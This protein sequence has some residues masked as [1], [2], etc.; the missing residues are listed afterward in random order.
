MLPTPTKLP[1]STISA[2]TNK[3]EG[4]PVRYALY[5]RWS[6]GKQDAENTKEGQYN[7]LRAHAESKGGVVVK[8]YIDEGV[9]GKRD[10]R[11]ALNE[12]MRDA[13]NRIRPFDEVLVW[14]FDRFGRRAS[15]MDRRI[16]ELEE[17]GIGIVAIQQPIQGK[18]SVVRLFRT[19][20]GGL[21][22]YVSDNMGEDISRG[23]MT[24]ATH[25][26][27][28]N[29]SVP[30][31]YKREYR[32]DRNR[33]RPFLVPDP[34][35]SWIVVRAFGLYRDGSSTS[36]IAEVYR[37]ENVPGPTEKPWT[38]K[39]VGSMLKNIEYAGFIHFGKRSKFDD[40]E[41]IIPWPE[42]ELISLEEYNQV[43]EIMASRN[44]ENRHPREVASVHLLSGLVFCHKG[45]FKMSPT[46]GERSY[47]NCNGKRNGIC[48]ACDTPN[49][50][51]ERLDT[52]VLQHVLDRIIIKENTERILVIVA[53]SQTE[54]TMEVEE[55]LKNVN[56]EIESQKASRRKL[57]SFVEGE[58][59]VVPADIAERMVEIR[60]ELTRLEAKALEARA[61][62]SN[63]KAL[64]SNPE[65]VLAYATKLETYLRGSNVDLTK[66]I[67][68][69][70]IVEVRVAP[71]EQENT[72]NVTIKYRVPT[73][74][75]G[76]AENTDIEVMA[77]RK[78]A[79]S[80]GTPVKAGMTRADWRKTNKH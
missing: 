22:E 19:M 53:S 80:M 26:V 4:E 6:S 30:L 60:E 36:K 27:W 52:L 41:V 38:P 47:Y 17:L 42:M 73:P 28:T 23:R 48:P 43:Q 33:M 31:G 18:P 50:R 74:P 72:A 2:K 49:P 37:E 67:L 63:E 10:D 71:G 59:D 51:A 21:A 54:A 56:L 40:T 64:I 58:E 75:S 45:S 24:S 9:S 8:I 34:D 62:V 77:L 61:K 79:R 15:T 55:E 39:R 66:A 20:L 68:N 32:M 35:T 69:E 12:L 1:T 16:T 11:K 7:A 78:N 13:R 70:L 25:G 3:T 57:L 44:P 46:G 5:I 65:K 29:S 14:K 76:W